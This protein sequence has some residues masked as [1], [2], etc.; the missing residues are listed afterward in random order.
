MRH[1][2]HFIIRNELQTLFSIITDFCTQSSV[3]VTDHAT[4]FHAILHRA[5]HI[6]DHSD[7]V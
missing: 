5:K 3:S 1:K 4:S 2:Y 7:I 6:Q